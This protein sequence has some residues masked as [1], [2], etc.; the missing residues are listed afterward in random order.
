MFRKR[1]IL[2]LPLSALCIVA[3]VFSIAGCMGDEDPIVED[4]EPIPAPTDGSV[5]FSADIQPIFDDNCI[6]CHAGLGAP[7]GLDLRAQFSFDNLVGVESN[8]VPPDLRV[9]P[10]SSDPC[11]GG[12]YLVEKISGCP[13]GSE[14]PRVGERMPFGGPFLSEEEIILIMDWIDLGAPNN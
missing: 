13:L 7:Q 9:N 6:R 5:S 11:E 1:I 10:G 3:V 2:R 8:E 4:G 12:S 14:I